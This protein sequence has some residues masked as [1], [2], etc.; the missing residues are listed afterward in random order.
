MIKKIVLWV[1]W[2][3]IRGLEMI[4]ISVLIVGVITLVIGISSSLIWWGMEN[5]EY[6]ILASIVTGCIFIF[7]LIFRGV[8]RI[9]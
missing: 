4:G 8:G 5:G 3:F 6:L 2:T 1:L 9:L 7:G